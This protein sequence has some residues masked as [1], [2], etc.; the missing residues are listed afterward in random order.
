[1]IMILILIKNELCTLL[2]LKGI[3][4]KFVPWYLYVRKKRS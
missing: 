3:K 2:H 1:M 4:T